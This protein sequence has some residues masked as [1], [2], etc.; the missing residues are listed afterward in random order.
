MFECRLNMK[1]TLTFFTKYFFNTKIESGVITSNG[2]T[3]DIYGAK[4]VRVN[5]QLL[6][7]L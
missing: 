5:E 4:L 7:K 2:K 6:R 3:L 1:K